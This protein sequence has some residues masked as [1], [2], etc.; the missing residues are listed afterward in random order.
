[1]ALV[2]ALFVNTLFSVIVMLMIT[3]HLYKQAKRMPFSK[4]GFAA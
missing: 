4:G 1:M 3:N 2:L